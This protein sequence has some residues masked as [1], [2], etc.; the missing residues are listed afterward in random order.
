MLG[1]R[2]KQAQIVGVRARADAQLALELGVGQRFVGR[3]ILR[4][5]LDLV[6]DNDACAR[7]QAKP[8]NAAVGR[9]CAAQIRRN[10]VFQHFGADRQEQAVDFAAVQARGV[11]Q[12]DHVGRRGRAFGLEARQNARVIGIDPV[13]LDARGLGETVVQRFVR[14]VVARG[15]EVDDTGIGKGRARGGNGAG[16][17][18]GVK[19]LRHGRTGSGMNPAIIR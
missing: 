16:S 3:H 7:R 2:A 6:V 15:V 18:Q 13:H 4:L 11:D 14:A 17:N 9:G 19:N 12:Q 10:H 5:D 8:R 1:D